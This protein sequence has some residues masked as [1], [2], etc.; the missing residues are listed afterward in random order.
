MAGLAA[1][2]GLAA[3]AGP[4]AAQEEAVLACT[5]PAIR[6]LPLSRVTAAQRSAVI[7]CIFRRTAVEMNAQAPIPMG[8][9]DVLQSVVAGG[10]TVF[11]NYRLNV[12]AEDFPAEERRA[13]GERTR[14]NVCQ[15]NM[16]E[17]VGWGGRFGY[18]WFDRSGRLLHDIVVDRC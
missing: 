18:N 14:A 1:A 13:L 7:A 16:R 9:G 5:P 2:F 17:T 10:T 11:Y 4:A 15:S 12:A 3:T 6:N 8:N